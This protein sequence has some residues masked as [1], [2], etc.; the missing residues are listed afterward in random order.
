MLH[1][2]QPTQ[3]H[4]AFSQASAQDWRRRSQKMHRCT[5]VNEQKLAL[6][7]TPLCMHAGTFLLL[8]AV[9]FFQSSGIHQISL[10]A[11]NGATVGEKFPIA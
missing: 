8:A 6:A 11:W 4:L 3:F 5:D 1:T 10:Y 7:P 9:V 2:Q